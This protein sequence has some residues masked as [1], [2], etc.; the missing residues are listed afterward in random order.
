[1]KLSAL[2]TTDLIKL[3][4]DIT[5]D[6]GA[7]ND[8]DSDLITFY[9]DMLTRISTEYKKR[10]TATHFSLRVISPRTG[11]VVFKHIYTNHK[12]YRDMLAGDYNSAGYEVETCDFNLATDELPPGFDD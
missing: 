6:L 5:A 7:I 9:H 2:S 12:A 4:R 8:N 1:M 11:N 10:R 3:S